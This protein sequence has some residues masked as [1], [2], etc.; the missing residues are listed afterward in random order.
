MVVD[1]DQDTAPLGSQIYDCTS[2]RVYYATG[3]LSPDR[4]SITQPYDRS[5]IS[6]QFALGVDDG[7]GTWSAPDTMTDPRYVAI[8][9][10]S[11]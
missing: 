9:V 6:S 11:S 5:T 4:P 1:S 10:V 3:T 2:C 7:D 8:E